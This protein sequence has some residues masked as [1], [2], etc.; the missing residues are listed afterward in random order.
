MKTV[1]IAC[2]KKW[3]IDSPKIKEFLELSIKWATSPEEITLE[4]VKELN[5]SMILF[6]H[7][8]WKVDK[9]IYQNFPCVVFHT[10]PLPYGRGGSPIQNLI[11]KGFSSAPVNAIQMASNFDAG[12]IYLS[13][14]VSLAGNLSEIFD[15]ISLIIQKMTIKLT[16]E[17]ILPTPQSGTPLVFTRIDEEKNS[18]PINSENIE[19]LYNHIRMLDSP[20]YEKCH[21]EIGN[22]RIEFFN[23]ILSNQEIFTEAKINKI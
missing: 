14:N 7:W 10:S 1:L 16:T 23:S 11:L 5:P 19:D 2:S 12:D 22:Y 15:R 21:L 18:L 3:F 17:V 4:K 20:E 8:S 9:E 13:E 6:P